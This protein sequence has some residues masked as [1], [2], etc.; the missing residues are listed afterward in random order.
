MKFVFMFFYI[1]V[2]LPMENSHLKEGMK[3]IFT[4]STGIVIGAATC[5]CW[6][7]R[8]IE[9]DFKKAIAD[10]YNQGKSE[11]DEAKKL[12]FDNGWQEGYKHCEQKYKSVY[13]ESEAEYS[14]LVPEKHSCVVQ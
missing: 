6:L 11:L 9:E 8:E 3:T 4:L 1:G 10:A 14:Q 13:E 7:K 2:I 5:F 12:A